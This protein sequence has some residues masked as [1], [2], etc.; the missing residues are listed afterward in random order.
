MMMTVMAEDSSTAVLSTLEGTSSEYENNLTKYIDADLR[1]DTKFEGGGQSDIFTAVL[2]CGKLPRGV[3]AFQQLYDGPATKTVALKILR[4]M[5]NADSDRYQ[6]IMRRLKRETGLWQTLSHDNIVPL[7]GVYQSPRSPEVDGLVM[8]LYSG[9]LKKYLA[10]HEDANK[11]L[12]LLGTAKGIEYLH[13]KRLVHGDIKP[14]NILVTAEGVPMLSDF[15]TSRILGMKGYTTNLTTTTTYTAPEILDFDE[16][17]SKTSENK[18]T[19]HPLSSY[20][21]IY[22]FGMTI[23]EVIDGRA[24]FYHRRAILVRQIVDGLRPEPKHHPG[25]DEVNGK[26]WILLGQCWERD[27]KLRPDIGKVMLELQC[28]APLDAA[29]SVEA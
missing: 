7:F 15:G 9:D 8:P 16:D 23:L 4:V 13:T 19:P 17:D 3:S 27:G 25:I 20:S 21:D 6:I 26:I 11:L 24:P 14:R 5:A 28:L 29:S 10:A 1:H 12:L 2:D 22:S 18:E